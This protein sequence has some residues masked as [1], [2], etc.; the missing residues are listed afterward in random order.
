[1]DRVEEGR[2]SITV[3][4]ASKSRRKV[5]GLQGTCWTICV[6]SRQLRSDKGTVEREQRNWKVQ[7]GAVLPIKDKAERKENSR[8]VL[9]DEAGKMVVLASC[10]DRGK[11]SH[12]RVV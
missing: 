9:V 6:A 5:E 4:T 7:D 3:L 11:F 2:V 12:S 1:M 8:N 10:Q